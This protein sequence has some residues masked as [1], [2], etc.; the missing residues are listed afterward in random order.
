MDDAVMVELLLPLPEVELADAC[1]GTR[2][3]VSDPSSELVAGDGL[4][5]LSRQLVPAVGQS[6]TT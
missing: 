6:V 4:P 3:E 5:T 2:R 1:R